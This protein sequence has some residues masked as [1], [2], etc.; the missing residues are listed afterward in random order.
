[1][2]FRPYYGVCSI[3]TGMT[4]VNDKYSLAYRAKRSLAS[5]Q[6]RLFVILEYYNNFKEDIL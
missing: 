6:L 4:G 3:M 5:A 2:Q 1:M